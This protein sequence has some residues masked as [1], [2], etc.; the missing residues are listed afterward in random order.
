MLANNIRV[1]L[2]VKLSFITSWHMV[3]CRYPVRCD[4]FSSPVPWMRNKNT[5]TCSCS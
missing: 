3:H 2:V 4:P 5:I 1:K